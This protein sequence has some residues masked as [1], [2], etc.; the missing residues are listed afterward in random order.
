MKYKK[1]KEISLFALVNAIFFTGASFFI[2]TVYDLQF[3]K[4]DYFQNQAL[5]FREKVEVLEAARGS[6]YDR[7]LNVVS[8]SVQ[9]FDIGIRP[10]EV[11][12]NKE[13]SE[14]LSLFLDIDE[15]EIQ[16]QI[17][18]RNS[19]FYI[20]RNVDFEIGNEIKSW[21]YKGIYPESSSKRI[22]HS[23][24]LGKIVG[25]VD[26]D[27]NGIYGTG[28]Q[29]FD[30]D[31]VDDRG[32]IKIHFDN[33]GY[34]K[35]PKKD[36]NG[37]YL[38]QITGSPVQIIDE[39]ISTD[40]CEGSTVEFEINATSSGGDISYQWQFF[41]LENSNWDNLSDSGSY[42]GT[43]SGKLIISS[44]S[45]S[46]DGRYRV[47]LKSETYL[48]ES[49][50]DG[51]VNLSVNAAPDNPIVSQ[52][53]TFCQSDSS[54]ISDLNTN[55]LGSNT[56]YWYDSIDSTTPLDSSTLLEHNTFY[57]AE[58][59]DEKGCVSSGRTES[60]AFISNPVLTSNSEEL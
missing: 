24:S 37:N 18:S 57:Y 9:S 3:S 21:N 52:I 58:Y 19:F 26:P 1:I 49:F 51:N 60:K 47:A 2:S 29:T 48:C 35:D 23:N 11:V 8:S 6:I 22:L 41:N 56:L 10:N 28:A 17:E 55:N 39:P 33:G 5:S 16:H 59:V 14:I 50:S 42:S 43:S 36:S 30:N 44:I 15:S 7:N 32:R 45:T 27:N 53:Q 25:G 54:K 20:K 46:M 40:G 38:F 12:E 13:L 4:S 31:L 34:N